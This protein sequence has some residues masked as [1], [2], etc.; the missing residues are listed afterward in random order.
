MT[1]FHIIYRLEDPRD[2]AVRY[3]GQTKDGLGPRT[4]S[5]AQVIIP[6][7]GSRAI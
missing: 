5:T 7:H 6:T 3:V 4:W 1:I 2:G